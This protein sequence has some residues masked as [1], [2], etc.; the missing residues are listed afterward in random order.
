[1]CQSASEW[2]REA[3]HQ[4]CVSD[5]YERGFN[6][7]AG[8][9]DFGQR[10]DA[11]YLNYALEQRHAQELGTLAADVQD[12]LDLLLWCDVLILNFPIF[13]CAPP[14]ILKGWFDRVLVSGRVYGGK[15]FYD[16]GG[17]VGKRA[18]V[19]ATIGGQQHMFAP[20]GIHGPIDAMLK[21]VLQG[22]LAYTGMTVLPPFIAWH[23]PYI[24]ADARAELLQDYRVYL[25]RLDA[26][27]PLAF[28]QL[29]QFDPQLRPLRTPR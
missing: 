25:S 28:P 18:L 17:L 4:V 8:P 9:N 1:M 6:P 14:A 22:T 26:L 21:P 16:R 24:T 23:V 29:D 20:D 11:G 12:E 3:G 7:V 5:L 15:R 27:V 19:A 2:L 13:W 10:R